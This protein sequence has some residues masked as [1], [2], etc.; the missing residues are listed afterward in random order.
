MLN[1][2]DKTLE[3]HLPANDGRWSNVELLRFPKRLLRSSLNSEP[4]NSFSA[5]P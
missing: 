3:E 2:L 5:L 1:G 4:L